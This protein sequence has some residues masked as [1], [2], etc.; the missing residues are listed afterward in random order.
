VAR[1]SHTKQSDID[2]ICI[3]KRVPN[4][5]ILEHIQATIRDILATDVDL[6]AMR[7]VQSFAEHDEQEKA[8]LDNDVADAVDIIGSTPSD[9]YLSKIIYKLT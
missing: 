8:F 9:I 5:E 4:I 1:N 3:W 2:L 6:I 7:Y